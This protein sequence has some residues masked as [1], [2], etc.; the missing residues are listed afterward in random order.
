MEFRSDVPSKH[1]SSVS[2]F[3]FPHLNLDSEHFI[4]SCAHRKGSFRLF[5]SIECDTFV[6]G[7]AEKQTD[8]FVCMCHISQ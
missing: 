6:I 8:G 5:K 1:T 3:L 7:V 2:F 4:N